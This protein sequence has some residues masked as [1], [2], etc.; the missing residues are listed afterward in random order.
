M[1][2]R[3]RLNNIEELKRL[4]DKH[5]S[6]W[7]KDLLSLWH[8]SGSSIPDG[9]TGLRLAV[10]NNYLN[11]YLRGQSVARVGFD[12]QCEPYAETHIKYAVESDDDL[13]NLLC[14]SKRGLQEYVRL[15]DDGVIR[16][17]GKAFGSYQGSSTLQHWIT[18]AA[19]YNIRKKGISEKASVDSAVGS[20]S[21]VID[22]EMALPAW[23]GSASALRIDLVSLE[24]K[25][26][27]IKLVFWEAKSAHDSR[28]VSTGEPKVIKQFEKYKTYLSQREHRIS[29]AHA[30]AEVCGLLIELHEMARN[31]NQKIRP[32]DPLI[33]Q[34]ATAP[35][36]LEVD[37]TPRL[38]I[39]EDGHQRSATFDG[40]LRRLLDIPVVVLSDRPFLLRRPEHAVV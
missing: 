33:M 36:S 2:F 3:R 21:N 40:H 9:Q 38:V 30:Y 35:H 26:K 23:G 20:N 12:R 32:L 17:N 6:N 31:L 15:T 11:F 25:N 8:P 10:R 19:K 22:L 13:G 18:R 7:W 1:N 14:S 29:V 4:T 39:F 27:R 37:E 24:Q 16:R 34:V 28:L 5:G